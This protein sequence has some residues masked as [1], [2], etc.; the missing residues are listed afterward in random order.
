MN[1]RSTVDKASSAGFASSTV[2]GSFA[3][4]SVAAMFAAVS[5]STV[6]ADTE[7]TETGGALEEIVVTA[8]K[9]SERLLDVPMSITALSGA[10]LAASQS[11]QLEDF[12][13]KAPGVSLINF[14]GAGT[15][16]VIRGVTAGS[17]PVNSGVATY[18]DETPFTASGPYGAQ[19]LLTPN[20]DTFDMQRIEVLRGPQGTLY[21]ANSLG[22][23]L[24]YVT[25][26]PDP[27]A[28]SAAA[29]TGVSSVSNGGTGYDAHGM[30]NLPLAQ[31]LALRI[32]GYDNFYPGFIDDPSR[33]LSDTNSSRFTGTR[34]AL[35]FA[36]SDTFSVRLSALFQEKSWNDYPDEDVAPGTLQPIYGNYIQEKYINNTGHSTL[37]LYNATVN[38]DAGAVRLLSTTSYYS[39][40][41]HIRDDYETL[42]GVASSILGGTYGLALFENDPVKALT[43]E[44]RLSSKEEGVFQW[45]A[46]GYF[47]DE[48]SSEFEQIDPINGGSKAILY[49]FPLNF[50][51]GS[52][53]VHYRE[54][55]GFANLDYHFTP[56]FDVALGGRYS[57]FDQNFHEVGTGLLGGDE[58]IGNDASQHVFTYSGDV[59]W[60]VLPSVMLYARVAEGYAPGGPN[61]QLAGTNFPT[62]YNS[63]TTINYEAGIKSGWLNGALTAELSAFDIHWRD[64]QLEAVI[65][66]EGGVASGGGA[67]S[68][69][70]EWNLAYIPIQGLTLD[71]NGAYTDARLTAATPASVGGEPGD[72]LPGVAR[73]GMSAGAEYKKP[74]F[75][76]YQGFVAVDSRFTGNRYSDFVVGSPRQ[77]IPSFN[78]VDLRA[79]LEAAHWSVTLY[80]KNVAN[81]IAINYVTAETLAGGNG[82]QDASLYPPRT[83]GLSVT[84]KY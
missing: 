32:V 30:L 10:D 54:F 66:G 4:L 22:G 70:A 68:S 14:G 23:V 75:T 28:F 61:A 8:Q 46:G 19:Y 39:F 1:N 40:R 15:Q 12:A 52:V 69:G 83:I 26:A 34:A 45:Q 2:R 21:G 38:W 44:L 7:P 37:D 58:D 56:T 36:P 24:K 41:P 25:N 72:R 81:K 59:R 42:N 5:I 13:G 6:R 84:A 60:H 63:S 17:A 31:N 48:D 73:W 53:P 27:S 80:A 9:R 3:G 57:A 11:F 47:T 29:E 49:N 16:V 62:T 33:G 82:P 77:D 67:R 79:G 78:I 55:A 18:I 20:I 71:F 74:L 43:E 50:L 51:T 65:N 35:L 64:I 76:S